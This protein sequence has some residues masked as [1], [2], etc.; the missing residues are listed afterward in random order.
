[1]KGCMHHIHLA[2]KVSI[3]KVRLAY[4]LL[5]AILV[6]VTNPIWSGPIHVHSQLSPPAYCHY[7]RIFITER[8]PRSVHYYNVPARQD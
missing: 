5:V 6:K 4:R 8:Q 1:M 3:Q 7:A 2:I